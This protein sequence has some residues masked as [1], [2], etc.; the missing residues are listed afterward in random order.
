M[1]TRPLT[2]P[3]LLPSS[4]VS[5]VAN[6]FWVRL[7]VWFEAD[8]L[9]VLRRSGKNYARLSPGMG[10]SNQTSENPVFGL[11]LLWL[12]VGFLWSSFRNSECTVTQTNFRSRGMAPEFEFELEHTSATRIQIVLCVC[13]FT[14]RFA[15]LVSSNTHFRNTQIRHS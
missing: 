5:N 12:G 7:G 13:S 8:Q 11:A 3:T 6:I 14:K 2:T 10:S 9:G 1:S 4:D 15:G